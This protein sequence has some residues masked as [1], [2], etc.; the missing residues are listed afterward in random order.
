MANGVCSSGMLQ[1][2][3]PSIGAA[4][5]KAQVG[6]HD[7]ADLKLYRIVVFKSSSARP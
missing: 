4:T 5:V 6:G 7:V 2:C 3:L 1:L